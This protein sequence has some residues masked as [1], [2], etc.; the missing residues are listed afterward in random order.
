MCDSISFAVANGAGVH[1]VAAVI[2]REPSD[3]VTGNSSSRFDLNF[4]LGLP[5][6]PKSA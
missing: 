1:P 2:E 6:Q 3:I 5:L 4:A